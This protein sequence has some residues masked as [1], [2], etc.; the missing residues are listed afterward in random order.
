MNQVSELA[1][2]ALLVKRGSLSA[3]A[4]ELAVTPPAVSKRLAAI[5]TRLG[6]TLVN[7]TTRRLSL[8]P[9]GEVYLTHAN[10]ILADIDELERLVA[11]RSAVPRGLLRVN[12]PLGFGRSYIAPAVSA[13]AK[14]FPEVE[15]RLELTDRPLGLADEG[16][17]VSIR[18]G[19]PPDAR[20]V[21]RKIAVNRRLICASPAYLRQHGRP[22]TP[23]DLARHSCLVLRQNDAA[24]GLWQF[25]RGR[26]THSVKV[27]GPLASN[28]GEVV[29]NWAL[30]GHGIAMRAEWDLARYVRSGRLELLLE[31]WATPPADI[32]A[33]YPQ[34]H[35]LS[36]RVREF[37]DFLVQRFT[38]PETNGG[39]TGRGTTRW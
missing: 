36:A 31:D 14:R 4:R 5:E 21:A 7:R 12:A 11:S 37:V 6:V 35:H 18:F 38:L 29:L 27:R 17:D 22:E 10:R 2:V 20:L 28:D 25:K 30:D 8:T 39:K 13:F 9:E 26:Q 3:A 16:I 15:V 34:R 23:P 24:Y 33:L 32:Y 1:F 19:E